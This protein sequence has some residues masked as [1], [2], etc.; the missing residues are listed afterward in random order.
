MDRFQNPYFDPLGSIWKKIIF[1][2]IFCWAGFFPLCTVE[3]WGLPEK[4]VYVEEYIPNVVVELRYF[5]NDNF[6]GCPVDGYRSNRLILTQK[7][8]EALKRVQAD[9]KP[10]GLGIKIL[11]AYRPQRAVNHFVRWAKD[12]SDTRMKAMYYPGVDKKDLFKKGYI[13]EKSS[14]S[15]GSTV[16]LT[17]INIAPDQPSEQLDMGTGFDF[18]SPLSW[19]ASLSVSHSARAHRMLLQQVM[20]AHGFVP[21]FAEWWHFTLEDEPF[22]ETYFDFPIE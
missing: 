10:F 9:L 3:V 1:L 19:P 16:D 21:Y 22:P 18:F 2:F 15:R 4:F 11:D 12:L 8:A 6:V 5:C 17:L 20:V 7:A 14:H 13:A